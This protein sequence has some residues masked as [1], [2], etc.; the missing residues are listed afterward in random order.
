MNPVKRGIGHLMSCREATRALS[1][2][3]ER[4]LSAFERWRLRLHLQ[5]CIACARFERQLRFLREAL[6]RYRT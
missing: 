6:Q 5:V 3:Q 1:Q 4:A 2:S